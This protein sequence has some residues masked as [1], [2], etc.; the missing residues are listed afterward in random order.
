MKSPTKYSKTEIVTTQCD[1]FN[2]KNSIN[3]RNKPNTAVKNKKSKI[4][5]LFLV[6]NTIHVA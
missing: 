6:F 3:G 2:K 4:N 5:I 1:F